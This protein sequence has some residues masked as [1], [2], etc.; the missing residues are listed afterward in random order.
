[1]HTETI[2]HFL[3][4]LENNNHKT[5]L[6]EHQEAYENSKESLLQI[7]QTLIDK[8]GYI[9][10]DIASLLPKACVFRINRDLRFTKDKRPYK[11]YMGIY[12]AKGG[13]KSEYAGYYLH[14]QP[15]NQSFIA[16]GIFEPSTAIC[17]KIRQEIDY[18]GNNLANILH[19]A[20]F[21]TCFS[22]LEG[23]KLKRPPKGYAA[24]HPYLEWLKLKSFT[25]IQRLPDATI[26]NPD[27]LI[28][29]TVQ[30]CTVL[31]PL[32]QFFNAVFED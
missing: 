13:K 29:S 28:A 3:T 20:S 30:A 17:N 26:K 14:I 21:K 18:N 19:S 5:W 23:E 32:N 6:H 2:L 16:G 10:P 12:L 15:H 7:A 1:M 31:Y 22:G 8:I 25:A 24:E 9:D 11:E 27:Q 4:A